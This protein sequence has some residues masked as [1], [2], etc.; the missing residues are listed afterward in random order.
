MKRQRLSEDQKD[1]TICS[2][3]ETHFQYK[4]TYRL[5]INEW[6]KIYHNN[7]NQKETEV[8]ILISENTDFKNGKLSS[9]KNVI[10]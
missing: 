5:K 7:T 8:I 1:S 10:T 4:D 2:L 9:M 3:H 6:R